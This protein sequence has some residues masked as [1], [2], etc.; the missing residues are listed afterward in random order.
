MTEIP[1]KPW[2]TTGHKN[3]RPKNIVNS[4]YLTAEDLEQLNIE[5]FERYEKIKASEQRSESY[6]CE[7]AEIVVVAFG[8][9]ARIARSA[10]RTAREQGIKAG[11][12]RPITLWPFPVDA[13]RET[14][15]NAKHYLSVEMNM[16]QMID[17]VKLAV[18][19]KAPV[20]FFG[21][22]GG[23]I[24]TPAEVLNKI[25]EINEKVGE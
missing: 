8:A 23:V 18:E 7:D 25:V 20:D 3:A 22:T 14:L 5:R 17:D 9:S 19:G 11:L 24:P 6:L 1:E 15:G 16:G 10:V 2:A 13:V 21:R 4:L 12:L